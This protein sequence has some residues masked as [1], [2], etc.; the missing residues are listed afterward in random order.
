MI[1]V[2][3]YWY[4][5][6]SSS[7]RSEDNL[8]IAMP[9]APNAVLFFL[10]VYNI[11]IRCVVAPFHRRLA[12]HR[13]PSMRPYCQLAPDIEGNETEEDGD[14]ADIIVVDKCLG[15]AAE[16]GRLLRDD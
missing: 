16:Q 14:D 9:F 3:W 15:V 2:R 1:K 7:R 5:V 11:E 13:F 6:S 12:M 4:L 8:R 10:N